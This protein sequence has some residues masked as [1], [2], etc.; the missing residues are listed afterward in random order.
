MKYLSQSIL[1]VFLLNF[2]TVLLAQSIEI[3]DNAIDDDGDGLIDLNDTDCFCP[4]IEAISLI[5]NPSFEDQL[6]CPPDRS[7]MDCADTWIQASTPTTDYI[8]TCGW[9]GWVGL[10][11][12]LPIPDGEGALGF[13]DGRF[14]SISGG[15]GNNEEPNPNWK[16]YAGACLINPLRAGISYKFKFYIG[17]T[18]QPFSP[19][20]AITFFGTTDCTNL[21]FGS[22]D[23]TFGCPTNSPDWMQLSA[24][25]TSGTS[26]WKELELNVTPTVDIEAIAIGPPCQSSTA[27]ENPY[28][29]FDNLVLAEQSAFEFEIK[30]NNQPCAQNL[31]FE[32]PQYDSLGYQWYKDGIAIL[33]ATN[34]RLDLP[35]GKGKYEVMLTSNEGCQVTKPF[36]FFIPFKTTSLVQTICEGEIYTLGDQQLSTPGI[37]LDT[38]KSVNNCDSMVE[39]DLRVDGSKTTAI[40]AKI[41][42]NEKYNIGDFSFS[43]P[44]EYTQTVP[45]SI[46]CD[47]TVNLQLD[48]YAIYFPNTFSPNG[49]G[50]NDFF[51][52]NAGEDLTA[53]NDFRIFDR[54]GNQVFQQTSLLPNNLSNGW[55]GRFDGQN[56]IEGVYLYTANLLMEDGIERSVSG[57]VTLV[58]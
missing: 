5:P 15:G 31:S 47:S 2:G 46:G 8:H 39:I 56:T 7:R 26:E 33:G 28:Y 35:P 43:Q 54:W 37:Y 23:R 13:R 29:F 50:I 11:M 9:T 6:C 18:E 14:T 21:P 10:P 34:P 40:N 49:D 38:L 16:E 48:Y 19:P 4:L 25:N 1:L 12:P 22:N 55:D 52:I 24:I 30:A 58:R 17:F 36:N 20:I 3:C 42:P 45:S 27:S 51:V 32:V 57:M 44:G 41:F 53:I